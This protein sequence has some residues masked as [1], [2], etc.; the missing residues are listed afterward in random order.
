MTNKQ[1]EKSHKEVLINY[2]LR[3]ANGHIHDFQCNVP[4]VKIKLMT[5]TSDAIGVY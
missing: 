2:K 4:A 1:G 5:S 3:H